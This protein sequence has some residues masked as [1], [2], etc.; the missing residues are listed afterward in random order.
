MIDHM[1]ASNGTPPRAAGT[2]RIPGCGKP[3]KI[4][5]THPASTLCSAHESARFG[6]IQRRLVVDPATGE[7]VT[8]NAL[9]NRRWRR[10]RAAAKAEA[11]R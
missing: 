7:T 4:Y 3:R 2:C 8:F 5:P 9:K 1:N 10:A 6:P 11:V